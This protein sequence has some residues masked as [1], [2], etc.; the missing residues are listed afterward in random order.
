MKHR[1]SSDTR[2]VAAY[3]GLTLGGPAMVGATRKWGVLTTLVP[4]DISC[5]KCRQLMGLPKDLFQTPES[6]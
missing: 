3:H 4:G 5:R 2:N 6:V 1:L